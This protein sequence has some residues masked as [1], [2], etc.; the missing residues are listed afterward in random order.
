MCRQ[1]W[2]VPPESPYHLHGHTAMDH[3][4]EDAV[5]NLDH[6]DPMMRDHMTAVLAQVRPKLYTY[7]QQDAHSALSKRARRLMMMLQ[8]LVNH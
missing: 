6:S 8:G 5:M 7:L 1:C 3:Y 2:C 4:L